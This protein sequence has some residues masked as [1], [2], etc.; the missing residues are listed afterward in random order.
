MIQFSE[1]RGEQRKTAWAVLVNIDI[2]IGNG[3]GS[4]LKRWGKRAGLFPLS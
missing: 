4:L 3:G 2:D 1:S